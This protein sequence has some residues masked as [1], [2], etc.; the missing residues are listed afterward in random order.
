M[1]SVLIVFSFKSRDWRMGFFP[2]FGSSSKD[3]VSRHILNRFLSWA[4]APLGMIGLWGV[5][6]DDGLVCMRPGQSEGEAVFVDVYHRRIFSVD[7]I[8]RMGPRFKVLRLDST[9]HG[10]NIRMSSEEL[11][12]LL[13]HH[14]AFFDVGGPSV[15]VRQMVQEMSRLFEGL[16]HPRESFRQRSG[17]PVR[18]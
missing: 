12:G 14:C 4:L 5:P 11:L 16:Y 7:G 9:L 6:V 1:L 13:L 10:K 2:D 15:P 8:K 18:T 17:L 3:Q